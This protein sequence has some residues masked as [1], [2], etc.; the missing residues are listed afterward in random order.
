MRN[1]KFKK[2]TIPEKLDFTK[3]GVI[4]QGELLYDTFIDLNLYSLLKS[5]E[6]DKIVIIFSN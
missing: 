5:D 4:R 1:R 2:K 6:I 3:E